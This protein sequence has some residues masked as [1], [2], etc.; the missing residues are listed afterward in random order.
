[1]NV[2]LFKLCFAFYVESM[3]FDS[4]T[5]QRSERLDPSTETDIISAVETVLESVN[6]DSPRFDKFVDGLAV[7]R[8]SF[9]RHHPKLYHPGFYQLMTNLEKYNLKDAA[10]RVSNP[11]AEDMKVMLIVSRKLNELLASDQIFMAEYVESDVP[12]LDDF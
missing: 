3:E 11:I 7:L 4:L 1:M 8:S 10:M 6:L 12:D 2:D 5:Q 9:D